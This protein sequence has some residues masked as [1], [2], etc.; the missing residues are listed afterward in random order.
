[1]ADEP[2]QI[3][4]GYKLSTT[5]ST[6]VYTVPTNSVT[7]VLSILVSNTSSTAVTFNL[8]WV[9]STDSSTEFNLRKD[10]SIPGKGR[11]YTSLN[12][13]LEEADILKAQ[14][15]VADSLELTLNLEETYRLTL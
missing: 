3:N 4:K 1:M 8:S 10:H 11:L 9:D 13:T 7:K 15:S 14:A 12:L 2:R 6:S 5:T